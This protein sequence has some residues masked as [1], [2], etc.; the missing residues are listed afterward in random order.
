M[1][2]LLTFPVYGYVESHFTVKLKGGSKHG[3]N[4]I[5]DAG[6]LEN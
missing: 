5:E 6:Y 2:S 4:H 1:L 3:L